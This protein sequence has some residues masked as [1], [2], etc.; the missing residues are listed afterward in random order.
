[1][2]KPSNLDSPSNETLFFAAN[3]NNINNPNIIVDNGYGYDSYDPSS[4]TFN[5]YENIQVTLN[6]NE[7]G[8]G[9]RIVG[10]SEEASNVAVGSIV[11]GGAAHRDGQLR[12]GDEIVTINDKNVMGASHQEVVQCMAQT[13]P[14]VRIVIRRRITRRS[15]INNNINYYYYNNNNDHIDGNSDDQLLAGLPSSTLSSASAAYDVTL[16]RTD[17]EGFGFVII[18]CGSCALIGRIIEGSPAHR[19]QR[20]HI[21]DRI[22]AVNGSDVTTLTHPEIVNKI[23]ESGT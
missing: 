4:S 5:H 2:I 1:M 9:F 18:S 12:A 10:G 22:I 6:R 17:S 14:T 11:I 3:G 8:F 7:N 19:C 13:G 15:N 23:K 20:L 21:R 16:Y